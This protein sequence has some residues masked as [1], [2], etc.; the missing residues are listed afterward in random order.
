M[1]K[2]YLVTTQSQIYTDHIVWADS[3]HKAQDIVFEGEYTHISDDYGYNHEE[4]IEI[5]EL[6]KRTR[7]SHTKR[8]N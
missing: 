4:I 3:D 6:T 2:W 8:R 1:S 7:Q 5:K